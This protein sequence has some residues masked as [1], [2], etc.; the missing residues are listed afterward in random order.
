M[1]NSLLGDQLLKAGLVDDRNAQ[2][3]CPVQLRRWSP[4]APS[5]WCRRPA[6]RRRHRRRRGTSQ[7]APRRAPRLLVA[8]KGYRQWSQLSWIETSPKHRSNSACF[9]DTGGP[10][11]AKATPGNVPGMTCRGPRTVTATMLPALHG[12]CVTEEE[13]LGKG[14]VNSPTWHVLPGPSAAQEESSS[15]K[16]ASSIT[17][18]PSSRARS[19]FEPASSPAST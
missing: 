6:L 8:G 1:P 4:T 18:T 3:L 5:W 7:Q 14:S 10:S 16:P 15:S 17:G 9:Y 13:I 11:G 19:S 2:L 12:S